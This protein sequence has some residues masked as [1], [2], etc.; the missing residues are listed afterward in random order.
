MSLFKSLPEIPTSEAKARAKL[1]HLYK[2]LFYHNYCYYELNEPEISDEDYDALFQ[3]ALA[4]ERAYPH[5]KKDNTPTKSVGYAP[6]EKFEKVSHS[7]PMLSLDNAFKQE[8]IEDFIKR[9]KK[10]L[11]LEIDAPLEFMAE[12]KIDGLSAA[13]RYEKGHLVLGCTRG[14]GTTGEN[15]THTLRTIHSIPH[16]LKGDDYPDFLEVRGEVFLSKEDFLLLN[17][18]REKEGLP[19]FANP[20]NA[21][22]GS[23]RQLDSVVAAKRPL[24]FFAYSLALIPEGIKTQRA[25]LDSLKKWG[26]SLGDPLKICGSLSDLLEYYGSVEKIRSH[27]PYDIDGVVYKV[28][29][30]DYQERLGQVSRSPRW[31]IAHKFQASQGET[32]LKAITIQVGRT[33]VLTPVAELEPIN[34]GGVLVSRATLHNADELLRKDIREGD[35]VLIQRAGDVIPQVVRVLSTDS[36]K[37]NPPFIFPNHCPICHSHAYRDPEEAATRC[38]GGF[39]CSAQAKERLKHFVSRHAFDIEGLGDKSI[40]FFWEQKRILSPMDIFTLEER[41]SK[42]TPSLKMIPGWGEKS[43]ENL[44]QAIRE[45]NHISFDRFLYALGIRHIGQ[46]TA[47][48]LALSYETA[49][50]WYEFMEKMAA[51][52]L[53]SEAFQSLISINMIGQTIGLSLYEFFR[54]PLNKKMV[55]DLIEFLTIIPIQQTKG[56]L[57]GKTFL[58]TGTLQTMTREEA[59]Q[60]V[61]SLGGKITSSLS[62]QTNFLVVGENPGSKIQKAQAIGVPIL[63]EQEWLQLIQKP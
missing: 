15:I 49:P 45:K 55:K 41:D 44:F 57:S 48:S 40:D 22:A 29:R 42:E 31:A 47:K 6:L 37:R 8:G 28:N 21:A 14:D 34:L 46:I 24:Q 20:R 54:E 60:K 23:V 36:S 25:L 32:I 53:E 18:E 16:H 2:E 39:N 9:I 52:S 63:N 51:E 30:L 38:T 17:E 5:L 59:K 56:I 62:S 7:V 12:P 1:D 33:G 61:E 35:R 43:A 50:A 26:F 11:G 19:A 13:L 10:F 58:F 4:L 3:E 27:L